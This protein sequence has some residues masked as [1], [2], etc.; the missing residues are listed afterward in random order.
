MFSTHIDSE[1]K[2]VT[3]VITAANINPKTIDNIQLAQDIVNEI[4]KSN[5]DGSKKVTIV[6]DVEEKKN[7]VNATVYDLK[8]TIVTLQNIILGHSH[9]DNIVVCPIGALGNVITFFLIPII[10]LDGFKRITCSKERYT[11]FVK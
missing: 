7:A 3:I 10:G 1:N 5:E 6:I 2:N 4:N 11:Y 8:T 9:V